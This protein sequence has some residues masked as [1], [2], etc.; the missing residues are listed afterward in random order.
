MSELDEDLARFEEGEIS[1]AELAARHRN[2]DLHALRR[3][4]DQLSSLALGP[5]PA[6]ESGW[7]A[8]KERLPAPQP[9]SRRKLGRWV[10][11]PIM[12]A[13]AATLML[14]G[15][16]LA[17]EPLRQGASRFLSGVAGVIGNGIISLLDPPTGPF[18]RDVS[19]SGNEDLALTWTPAVSYND[20]E[21]LSCTLASSAAHGRAEVSSD[22]TSGSYVP[23]LNFQGSDVFV[24]LVSG[25][26]NLSSSA[27]VNVTVH[28][29]NDP[30]V[31]GDDRS[32][33]E[34][35]SPTT[36]NVL[37]NDIDV[38]GGSLPESDREELNAEAL[39]VHSV[40]G[41][42]GLVTTSTT[43]A[44]TFTPDADF[45]GIDSFKYK[46]WDGND[47]F[48]TGT[49][50]VRVKAV[51]DVP[52]A[53]D[54]TAGGEEDLALDW[55]PSVSDVEGDTLT[56][57]IAEPAAHGKAE[58]SS[59]CSGGSFEPD[60]NWSGTDSFTYTVSDGT[61]ES[62]PAAVTLALDPVND[63]P[64]VSDDAATTA[65]D[66]PVLIQVLA[67]D[68]DVDGTPLFID[69][70]VSGSHGSVTINGD[71]TLAYM[72]DSGF[73]GPDSFTYTVSDGYGGTDVGSV[74]ISV[75]PASPPPETGEAVQ[76]G[77]G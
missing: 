53:D 8:L 25:G 76:P 32:W 4:R 41:A 45:N 65:Q 75:V 77:K 62:P 60:P 16:V 46:A 50:S 64:I 40:H 72:P 9:S 42:R 23:D 30:P 57:A 73:V 28:G 63:V 49:V 52:G 43:G 58:V 1:F 19:V 47:G 12:A 39:A 67:N 22:C 14:A 7:E 20:R 74:V 48:A 5:T 54:V 55:A 15:V 70:A 44:I 61:D 68:T 37:A 71:G 26:D 31:A 36:F 66:T 11:R 59:D 29:V 2:E 35:D 10:R 3:L 69:S 51:N 34:E 27:T 13:A 6:P 56:C 21:E 38:D 17:V 18:A 33:T 24:Y